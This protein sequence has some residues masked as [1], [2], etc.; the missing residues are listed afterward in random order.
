MTLPIRW[1]EIKSI[2]TQIHWDKLLR[3]FTE[4]VDIPACNGLILLGTN[5][6]HDPMLTKIYETTDFLSLGHNELI[7][8]RIVCLT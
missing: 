7:L 2:T 1:I 6:L 5:P 3:D 8:W 4:K